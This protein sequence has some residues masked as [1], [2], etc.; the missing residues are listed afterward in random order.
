MVILLLLINVIILVFLAWFMCP[1]RKG[2][3]ELWSFKKLVVVYFI[4]SVICA[5]N[6]GISLTVILK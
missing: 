1:Y 2:R 6:T 5:A 3:F 4:I